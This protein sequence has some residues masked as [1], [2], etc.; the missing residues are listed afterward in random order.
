MGR[1]TE[2]LAPPVPL[3]TPAT[4]LGPGTLRI[5]NWGSTKSEKLSGDLRTQKGQERGTG[6]A[7]GPS[8][9]PLSAASA[10]DLPPKSVTVHGGAR[11]PV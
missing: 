2:T 1:R 10:P 3:G 6:L 5:G 7:S 8:Q 9:M 11:R 4:F